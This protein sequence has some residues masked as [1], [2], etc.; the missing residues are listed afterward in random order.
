MNSKAGL[1]VVL[2]G[3]LL[4]GCTV[5]ESSEQKENTVVT[6]SDESDYAGQDSLHPSEVTDYDRAAVTSLINMDMKE[7]FGKD[8]YSTVYED[9]INFEKKN[10]VITASGNY[11]C[12]VNGYEYLG[13]EYTYADNVTYYSL[14]SSDLNN[15]A[16][17]EKET[18]DANIF[19]RE[20][21][22]SYDITISYSLTV[23][24]T[25]DGEGTCRIVL[26]DESGKEVTEIINQTG[27][28]DTVKTVQVPAGNY[29][30]QLYCTSGGWSMQY[31]TSES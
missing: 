11:V 12:Y 30:L 14:L 23:T 31:S 10:G 8:G 21:D 15:E 28:I 19:G 18:A 22:R 26:V 6:V 3:F 24:F 16:G 9:Y 20:P 27:T 29:K 25:H 17:E 2:S 7:R 4:A 5:Q 1:C 13:F